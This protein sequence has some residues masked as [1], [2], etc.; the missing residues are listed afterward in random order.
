[1]TPSSVVRQP[2][3]SK[4]IAL[5]TNTIPPYRRE[6]FRLLHDAEGIEVLTWQ[7][8]GESLP[9][10]PVRAVSQRGDARLVAS[11][12]YRAVIGGLGG[13]IALPGAYAGARIARVP[14]VLWASMW[15][16]PST[17]AHRLSRLPLA[18]I[19]RGADA[20][21][22]YG[23][24][25]SRYVEQ[26]RRKGNVFVAP[27]AVD[28]EHFGRPARAARPAGAG[29]GFLLLYVGRLEH[30]KGI[31]V[32]LDA[33]TRA[34]LGDGATLALAGTG[35]ITP[36]GTG[37]LPLGHVARDDLPGL[38]AAADALVLPS[39]PTATFKEPWGL[40]VNEAMLQSTP[41]IASDAVGA[42]AGGLVV[43]D[44]NGRV[45]PHGDADALAS[46][47]RAIAGDPLLRERL[48]TAARQ[49]A[50][51]YTPA[52]WAAGMSQALHAAGA[53]REGAFC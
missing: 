20:V 7:D 46:A 9:G 40:V 36:A 39:I 13:R 53:G 17:A 12:R 3:S 33:W 19:Y 26:H 31:D 41:V 14:F 45:V 50:S 32:L 30:E 22:T 44:R 16:H 21:A 42:A 4:P 28:T 51:A 43:D 23:P 29:D 34:G 10:V 5:V 35:P 6:P 11:G 38:Y 2:S 24:H 27:Q 18:A 48:G 1:M 49:D 25:V 37:V 47:I 8:P 15:D 52:A